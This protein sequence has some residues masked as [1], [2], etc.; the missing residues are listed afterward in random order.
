MRIN[1]LLSETGLGS[2]REV[3]QLIMEGRVTVNGVLAELT[4][5]IEEEDVVTLDGEELPVRDLIREF[6]AEQ[7]MLLAQKASVRIGTEYIDW[8]DDQTPRRKNTSGRSNKQSSKESKGGRSKPSNNKPS[9]FRKHWEDDEQEQ[10]SFKRHF[11]NSKPIP[12][13]NRQEKSFN[14][15]KKKGRF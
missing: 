12:R 14:P 8:E 1:K 3:E 2:R 13:N 7:K 10:P 11:S 6:A 4:D 15:S 9:K 5:I